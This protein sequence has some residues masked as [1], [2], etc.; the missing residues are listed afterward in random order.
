MP[1]SFS[2]CQYIG[3]IAA[4][5]YTPV[6]EIHALREEDAATLAISPPFPPLAASAELHDDGQPGALTAVGSPI[7]ASGM[8]S[9]K[10]V[11]LTVNHLNEPLPFA[12]LIGCELPEPRGFYS[13]IV[14]FLSVYAMVHMYQILLD[15]NFS[16]AHPRP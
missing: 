12:E 16:R 2:K 10:S 3:S 5:F 11:I 7:Y 15:C 13:L 14:P 9:V 1:C 6:C 4:I 8:P